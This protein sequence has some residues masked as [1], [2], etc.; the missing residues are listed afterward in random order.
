VVWRLPPLS[1]AP[2]PDGAASDAVGLLAE[3]VAAA[4]GG[5]PV[6]AAELPDLARIATWL[7]G[8]P[9]AIEQVAAQLRALAAG[10]LATRLEAT[11]APVGAS[12]GASVGGSVG[13]AASGRRLAAQNA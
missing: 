6:P 8:L 12:V 11:A 9:L 3:R 13:A 10:Q 1:L 7:D 2:G 5:Y 4:R